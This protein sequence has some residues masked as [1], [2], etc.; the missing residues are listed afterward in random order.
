ML[1]MAGGPLIAG[2]MADAT[3]NHVS[4]FTLMAA[5]SFAGSSC[6]LLASPPKPPR[7]AETQ[8]EKPQGEQGGAA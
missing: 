4:G 7:Q 6:F 1:G 3:G 2:F 5:A 8:P